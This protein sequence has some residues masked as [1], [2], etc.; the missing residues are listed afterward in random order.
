VRPRTEEEARKT[1]AE[2]VTINPKYIIP[3][4]CTGEVF[5]AEALRLM[6]D[7][8]IRPYVGNKFEFKA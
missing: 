6:P 7:K 4:H 8:V 2:M 5:I 3:M 1:A